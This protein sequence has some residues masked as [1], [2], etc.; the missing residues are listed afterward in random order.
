MKRLAVLLLLAV[1]ASPAAADWLVTRTGERIEIRGPWQ[2]KGKLVVFTR[3]DG[4]LA[5]LRV[6][7]VD[8]KASERATAEA[9]AQKDA[10]PP[11][12]APEKKKPVAVVTDETLNRLRNPAPAPSAEAGQP[13]HREEPPA[14]TGPAILGA[15]DRRELAEGEGIELFGTVQNPGT[16]IAAGVEVT[17]QLYDEAG[18]LLESAQ[19]RL[20]ESSISPEGMIH[21]RIPLP[22]VFS[23][24]EAKFRVK[25][26]VLDFDPV[27]RAGEG[28]E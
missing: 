12:A 14:S 21:F 27:G 25:S 18:D 5:S 16:T 10:P 23:F 20:D 19:A 1:V 6:S 4:S 22:G 17:V 13:A 2:L 7:E 28:P 3:V 24:A 15:W 11:A 9:K 26:F 8:L